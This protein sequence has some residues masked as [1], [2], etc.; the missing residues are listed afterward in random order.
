MKLCLVIDDSSVV[1][2]VAKRIVE[3][4]Q[5]VSLEAANAQDAMTQ[6][7]LNMPNV[8]M[9]DWSLPG[10][11]G[12]DL[13]RSIRA[14]DDGDLPHIIY[15]ATVNDTKAISS[16]LSAGADAYI[17]KPIDRTSVRDKFAEVGLA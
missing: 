7:S 17:L 1:R 3:D 14:Q 16:A 8:I 12:T 6:C 4:L 15:C 10:V 9:V 5:Y 11:E 2:K 13:I